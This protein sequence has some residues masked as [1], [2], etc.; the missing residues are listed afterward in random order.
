MYPKDLRAVSYWRETNRTVAAVRFI[1]FY[2]QNTN[3]MKR[4][5][6]LAIVID[7]NTL[8]SLN[9]ESQTVYIHYLMQKRL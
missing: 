6:N 2:A 5:I 1:K 4:V 7:E 8:S 3:N 9:I